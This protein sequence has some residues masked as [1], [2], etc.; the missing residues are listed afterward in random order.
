M[1]RKQKQE[2][3]DVDKVESLYM[4][5]DEVEVEV[6]NNIALADKEK[7][8]YSKLKKIIIWKNLS[9]TVLLMKILL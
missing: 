3:T 4:L 7:T 5:K 8:K 9:L 1:I 2:I 6:M